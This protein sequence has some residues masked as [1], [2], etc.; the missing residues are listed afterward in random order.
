[1]EREND[2]GSADRRK[3]PSQPSQAAKK[4]QKHKAD[5]VEKQNEILRQEC[6]DLET[7]ILRLRNQGHIMKLK[8]SLAMSS[9][10][11]TVDSM[12]REKELLERHCSDLEGK[13]ADLRVANAQRTNEIFYLDKALGQLDGAAEEIQPAAS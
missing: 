10:Q 1:M 7:S 2:T 4:L 13:I 5:D 8:T 11:S 3:N 6:Q 9:L 12:T